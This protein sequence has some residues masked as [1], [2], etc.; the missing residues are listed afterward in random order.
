M[1]QRAVIFGAGGQ[2]G[3]FLNSLLK[4]T[5]FD[6][7][8]FTHHGGTAGPA[9]DVSDFY[10]VESI[11]REYRPD[12]IFHLAARSSTRHEVILENHN[13]IVD[14][15]LAVIESV[16]RHIPESKVFIASSAL[17]FKNTG[18]PVTEDNDLITNTA[19][20]M[21]RVE[22]LHIVRYYRQRGRKIYVG[23]L[24]NHESP[25]RPSAS[26][27][28]QVAK[29]VVD[30]HKGLTNQLTIGNSSVIKEWAWAGDIVK[31]FIT[32]M[33]QEN[34]FEVCIG[35]GIGKSIREYASCCCNALNIS[36]DKH[37]V[38]SADFKAEC[39][40]LVNGSEIIYSLGWA[41]E[42]D[43]QELALRMVDAERDSDF[44]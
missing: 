35:D 2:D 39:P 17:I 28:R 20:A 4:S 32:L 23:F 21:A 10:Q 44:Q 15:A 16:D 30:I 27:A 33:S 6:V 40:V 24:F 26:V 36:L 13:A 38:E 12:M 8:S 41:P 14:G 31:A 29:N 1:R 34:I 22:A 37:L 7:L 18:R 19:Y 5:G 11:I 42:V 43:I 9:V 3:V 25:L